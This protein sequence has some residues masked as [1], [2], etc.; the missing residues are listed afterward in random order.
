MKNKKLAKILVLIL[1]VALVC[2]ALIMVVN[3][4][5]TVDIGV[6]LAPALTA[7]EAG[8]TE[9]KLLTVFTPTYNRRNTLPDT[10]ES[11]RAQNCKDFVWLIV[12]D[13][14]RDNTAELV[15]QWQSRDNGFEIWYIYKENGGRIKVYIK[16]ECGHHPHGLENYKMVVDEI[17]KYS[18][19]NL[20]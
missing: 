13:G 19:E 7:A 1:S 3:A 16:P 20:K 8:S 15:R 10:Y 17:E 9:R 18:K 5:D 11:L 6:D 4:D 2:G 12:D 14:S